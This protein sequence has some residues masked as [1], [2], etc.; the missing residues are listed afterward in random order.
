MTPFLLQDGDGDIDDEDDDLD[1]E[2]REWAEIESEN[3]NEDDDG[4]DEEE[5]EEE[6][7]WHVDRPG[8]RQTASPGRLTSVAEIPTLAP[9]HGLISFSARR[10]LV[11]PG[12]RLH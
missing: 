8:T 10:V 4:E 2:D 12:P 11:I 9:S 5:E 6:G 1:E 7:T 3:E